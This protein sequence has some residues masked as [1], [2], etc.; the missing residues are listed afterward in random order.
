MTTSRSTVSPECLPS[1]ND[2]YNLKVIVKPA[3]PN[4]KH[5]TLSAIITQIPT[6]KCNSQLTY[7]RP[8]PKAL[9]KSVQEIQMHFCL[10]PLDYV[11]LILTLVSLS[12]TFVSDYPV[13]PSRLALPHWC[14]SERKPLLFRRNW[15]TDWPCEEHCVCKAMLKTLSIILFSV[16][17]TVV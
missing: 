9:E 3:C 7:V 2:T 10:F 1:L 15:L 8:L 5:M 17:C 6:R 14:K 11:S 13:D 16:L 12:K 4:P